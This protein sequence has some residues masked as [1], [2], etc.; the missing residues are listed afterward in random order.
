MVGLG[1]LI[2]LLRLKSRISEVKK[3]EA[4]MDKVLELLEVIY[5]KMIRPILLKAIDDPEQEWDDVMMTVVDRIFN[6]QSKVEE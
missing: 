6:Y 2:L 4:K 3:G 1:D 5:A